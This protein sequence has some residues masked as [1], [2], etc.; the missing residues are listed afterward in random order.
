MMKITTTEIIQKNIEKK[1]DENNFNY[2]ENENQYIQL[3]S[4]W[5]K[6]SISKNTV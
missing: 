6:K 5:N 2:N 1:L 4:D 3:K